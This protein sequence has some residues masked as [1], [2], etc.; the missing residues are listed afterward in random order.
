MRNSLVTLASEYDNNPVAVSLE[1]FL[2]EV[3]SVAEQR[4]QIVLN[5]DPEELRA[6]LRQITPGRV[7]SE[8]RPGE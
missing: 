6:T 7:G 8:N 3:V 5:L 1:G 2:I 4:G